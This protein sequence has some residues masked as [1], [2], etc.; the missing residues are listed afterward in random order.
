M[1]DYWD[2]I[3]ADDRLANARRKLSMDELRMLFQHARDSLETPPKPNGETVR[4]SA[5]LVPYSSI[6]G[7]GLTLKKLD[8]RAG[9]IVN[10]IGTSEGITKEET[11]ALSQQFAW[12]ISN[13]G[14]F[15][16]ARSNGGEED[17]G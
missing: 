10:F 15:V 2:R 17:N 6:V 13:Y 1:S 3:K 5:E 12:F 14:C 8:G 9:F 16:P 11:T 4:L 7:G